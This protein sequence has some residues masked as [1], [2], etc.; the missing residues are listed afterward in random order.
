MWRKRFLTN[1]LTTKCHLSV[2]AP[3]SDRGM[4]QEGLVHPV[5]IELV[6][7]LHPQDWLT[8]ES[9]KEVSTPHPTPLP[10][11]PPTNRTI[12]GLVTPLGG[13]PG[14]GTW[15]IVN[16]CGSEFCSPLLT[17]PAL[18][19]SLSQDTA[20]LSSYSG[21]ACW[22]AGTRLDALGLRMSPSIVGSSGCP[23]A[24]V[25]TDRPPNPDNWPTTCAFTEIHSLPTSNTASQWQRRN[26]TENQVMLRF[27]GVSFTELGTTKW[28]AW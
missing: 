4:P 27:H 15:N 18:C 22:K 10:H 23:R 13:A 21:A 17:S 3:E 26:Q 24:E 9:H 6:T 19:Q 8:A 20:I 14:D 11:T 12:C 16:R 28:Q 2:P 7:L 5:L 25:V 1:S